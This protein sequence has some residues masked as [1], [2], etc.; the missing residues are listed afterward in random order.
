LVFADLLLRSPILAFYTHLRL[1]EDSDMKNRLQ[2][3]LLAVLM[4]APVLLSAPAQAQERGEDTWFI[5]PQIGLSYY[6]G[7]NEPTLGLEK[8]DL[9]E[10]L[11]IHLGLEIGYRYGAKYS[12]GIGLTYGAYG[13][14]ND[15]LRDTTVRD[16]EKGNSIGL[17]VI[18]TRNFGT[19]KISPFIKLGAGLNFSNEE[20]ITSATLAKESKIGFGP[21]LGV[22]LDIRMNDRVSL[23]FETGGKY[24]F[25]GEAADGADG[26]SVN[27]WLGWNTFS[28]AFDLKGFT[29]VMVTDL[30]CPTDAFDTGSPV[31]F[32]GSYNMD[33][34]PVVESAWAF[35]DGATASGMT[36]SH[37]FSQAGMYTVQYSASNGNGRAM[38]ARTCNVTVNDPCAAAVITSMTASNMAPDTETSVR[39]S[40]NTSGTQPVSYSWSFGDGTTSD[41]ANPNH[42]Y[43]EAGTYTV[44][45]DVTNCGGTVSRTMTITVTPYEAAIC[46][47]IEEMNSVFFAR[48]SSTLTAE[49]RAA[50]QENLEI[51]Q[52]CP[53]LNARV[54]GWSAPGERRAQQLSLDR[55]RA[56][57]QFYMDNGIAASRL[58]TAGMGRAQGMTSK[59][60]G[61]AQFSRADT[62]PVRD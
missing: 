5:R 50:L 47:E 9:F 55:A 53:N 30:I 27:D 28:V 8:G 17:N 48:N 16:Y 11:P 54:E 4:A 3:L 62:I 39:F 20:Q 51:L 38:D 1:F 40:A 37:A 59:K 7:T 34:S 25:P 58:V 13:N 44:T 46:R 12:A 45:L 52:L 60:E 31:T 56:V 41:A 36:A 22:G 29:P 57:E 24:V 19:G 26:G 42:T 23:G 18:G 10:T 43:S 35:G 21:I 14:L 49:G 32:T 33:A 61:L 15:F 6:T 2:A